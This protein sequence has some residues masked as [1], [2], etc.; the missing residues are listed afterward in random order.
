MPGWQELL[1]PGPLDQAPATAKEQ[2]RGQGPRNA[3]PD[4]PCQELTR[5][6]LLFPWQPS[7]AS[8]S[9]LGKTERQ[10]VWALS[11]RVTS[12]RARAAAGTAATGKGSQNR[13]VCVGGWAGLL[14][15]PHPNVLLWSWAS[16][17]SGVGSVMVMPAMSGWLPLN[18]WLRHPDVSHGRH[19]HGANPRRSVFATGALR[20]LASLHI[21]AQ[22]GLSLCLSLSPTLTLSSLSFSLS[23]S[24][25]IAFHACTDEGENALQHQA[26][27]TYKSQTRSPTHD[28]FWHR[29][30]R[31]MTGSGDEPKLPMS[32]QPGEPRA[33]RTQ[34]GP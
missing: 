18:D 2:Q 17:L 28:R 7:Y 22:L 25:S 16:E 14:R 34:R 20:V 10:R 21:A 30:I 9:L 26:F 11:C 8:L 1:P 32:L 5:S 13:P 31:A 15:M 6:S 23:C 24:P 19:E 29:Q 12:G 27:S 3:Q 33:V 4:V